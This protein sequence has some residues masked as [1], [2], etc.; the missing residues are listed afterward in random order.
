[1]KEIINNIQVEE[2]DVV[3]KELNIWVKIRLFQFIKKD[4]LVKHLQMKT[5]LLRFIHF[6]L[7]Q[8]LLQGKITIRLDFQV[9]SN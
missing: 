1:M 8:T 5:N 4:R 7:I 2:T 6:Q 9:K 3:E